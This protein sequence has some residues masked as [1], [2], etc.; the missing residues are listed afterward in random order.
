MVT[1]HIEAG[2]C[3][4]NT[5]V[6][7][8]ALPDG[9]IELRVTSDCP[10]VQCLA[11][12]LAAVDPLR[13]ITYRGEAPAILAAARALLPHPAC[14]VPSALLKAVEVAAGLALPAPASIVFED[15]EDE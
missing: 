13:E 12:G 14:V 3:G 4:F 9:Q 8:E 11:A 1:A 15:R 6:T 5:R 10:S 7:A 2:I